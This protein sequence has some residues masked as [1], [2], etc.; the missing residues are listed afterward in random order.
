[1]FIAEIIIR[2]PQSLARAEASVLQVLYAWPSTVLMSWSIT[3]RR[4]S[5]R[6][7]WPRNVGRWAFAP[8]SSKPMFPIGSIWSSSSNRSSR[9]SV[10]SISCS[11]TLESSTGAS[12]TRSTKNR[13]T[14]YDGLRLNRLQI[15]LRR[16][17]TSMLNRN[18]SSLSKRTS[19]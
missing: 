7:R 12:L 15:A 13:L 11:P 18:S 8:S 16:S 5:Q 14:R 6:R 10:V 4:P 2:V 17:S 3:S 19:I 9:N 1:M